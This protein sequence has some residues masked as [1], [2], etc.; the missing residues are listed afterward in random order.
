MDL[1]GVKFEIRCLWKTNIF[2]LEN[3][4]ETAF[5]KPGNFQRTLRSKDSAEY[6]FKNTRP[7]LSQS[8]TVVWRFRDLLAFFIT[9]LCPLQLISSLRK[10]IDI[11][12]APEKTFE[13][14][15]V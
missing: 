5:Y 10:I 2:S 7:M 15:F 4:S 6:L 13:D 12:E 8:A 14:Y 11:E 3:K 1:L 9:D